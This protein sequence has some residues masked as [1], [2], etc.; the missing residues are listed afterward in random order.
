MELDIKKSAETDED[1]ALFEARRVAARL[2]VA[3]IFVLGTLAFVLIIYMA[4]KQPDFY[5]ISVR[6]FLVV[7]GL[8]LAALASIFVVLLFRVVAGGQISVSLLGL[9]F[10]GAS[11]PVIM[12]VICFLAIVLAFNTLWDKIYT[13]PVSSTIHQ[14]YSAPPEARP[15]L[16]NQSLPRPS[17]AFSMTSG[18]RL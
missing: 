3:G 5:A 14:L 8:P 6:H 16:R 17:S 1:T 13:G 2:L 12:W 10:E 7:V 15:L 4:R 18:G 11:G 9:K